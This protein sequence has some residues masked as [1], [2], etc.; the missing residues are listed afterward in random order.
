MIEFEIATSTHKIRL[1]EPADVTGVT[2]GLNRATV[3]GDVLIVADY[4]GGNGSV[5]FEG[6][7]RRKNGSLA[8]RQIDVRV[9]VPGFT[10]SPS[11]PEAPDWL[12]EIVRAVVRS[13]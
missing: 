12:V 8:E 11:Y 2:S 7:P 1:A 6:R 4:G 3:N 13:A 10:S 5:R 9:E